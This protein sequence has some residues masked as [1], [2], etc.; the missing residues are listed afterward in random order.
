MP[1]CACENDSWRAATRVFTGSRWHLIRFLRSTT[2]MPS[3]A[4]A[5]PFKYRF[6]IHF[7]FD[8]V[9]IQRALNVV[10]VIEHELGGFVGVALRNRIRDGG[11]L[12][13]TA[14]DAN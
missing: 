8:D 3:T 5:S 12:V 10:E 1:C 14:T 13:G 6:E 11:V 4:V 7:I 2:A 9:E